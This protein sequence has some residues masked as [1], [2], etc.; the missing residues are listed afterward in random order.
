MSRLDF[1]TKSE[2]I[3]KLFKTKSRSAGAQPRRS[4]PLW[5]ERLEDRCLL[6][7]AANG[8]SRAPSASRERKQPEPP[9]RANRPTLA[10]GGSTKQAARYRGG[11]KGRWPGG[12]GP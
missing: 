6:T 2:R 9:P 4:P 5:L 3:G 10:A 12:G 11:G 1:F 8:T 7:G